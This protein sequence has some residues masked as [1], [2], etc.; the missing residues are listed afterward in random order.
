MKK[1]TVSLED[2]DEAVN[3]ILAIFKGKDGAQN[4]V[5]IIAAKTNKDSSIYDAAF[6]K[7]LFKIKP[8][9]KP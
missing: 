8:C 7:T 5:N 6:T 3:M 1:V 2:Q 9:L 4:L